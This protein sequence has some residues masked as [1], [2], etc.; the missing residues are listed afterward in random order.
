MIIRFQIAAKVPQPVAEDLEEAERLSQLSNWQL[1][2]EFSKGLITQMRLLEK[3]SRREFLCLKLECRYFEVYSKNFIN[4]RA[5][6][7]FGKFDDKLFGFLNETR[8]RESIQFSWFFLAKYSLHISSSKSFLPKN[9]TPRNFCVRFFEHLKRIRFFFSPH[10]F[11]Q[12][13]HRIRKERGTLRQSCR[14][15]IGGDRLSK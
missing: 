10:F 14:H 6:A 1:W 12:C 5:R 8:S 2:S 11:V 4:Q 3:N 7:F 9:V 15:K 13:V